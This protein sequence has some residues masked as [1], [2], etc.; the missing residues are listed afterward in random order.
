VSVLIINGSILTIIIS[1]NFYGL[2]NVYT[3]ALAAAVTYLFLN[4]ARIITASKVLSKL[5]DS[6]RVALIFSML[7]GFIMLSRKG[8][9]P[10]SPGYVW[11]SSIVHI[12]AIIYLLSFLLGILNITKPKEIVGI[13]AFSV[14]LLLP[15]GKPSEHK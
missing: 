14:L 11:L 9:L 2:I 1:N 8:T 7:S 12:A 13:C 15:T 10:V 6:I 4:E 3:S 5:Y